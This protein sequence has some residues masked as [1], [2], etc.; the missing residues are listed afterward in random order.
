MLRRINQRNNMDEVF[1]VVCSRQK[2]FGT[3]GRV[4]DN[5]WPMDK[6]IIRNSK[7]FNPWVCSLSCYNA[8]V[9]KYTFQSADEQY[10]KA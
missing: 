4:I 7:G 9:E 3:E 1:C 6:D 8:L 10:L 5:S 2:E